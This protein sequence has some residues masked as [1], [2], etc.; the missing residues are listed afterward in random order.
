MKGYIVEI[1]DVKK[2]CLLLYKKIISNDDSTNNFR[3]IK[4]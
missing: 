2:L 1:I 4:K 3:G